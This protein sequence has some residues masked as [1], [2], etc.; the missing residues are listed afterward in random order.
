[1]KKIEIKEN[2]TAYFCSENSLCDLIERTNKTVIFACKKSEKYAMNLASQLTCKG[3]DVYT[4]ITSDGEDN[5]SIEKALLLTQF[6]SLNEIRRSDLIINIGGG[7]VCDLGA[8]VASVYMRGIKYYNVPTTLL[9]AV[10]A[11]IGGKTA[12]NTNGSKNLWGTFYQPEK[13]LIDCELIKN[14]PENIFAEGLSEIV[15]YAILNEQFYQFLVSLNDINDIR[16][17]IEQV[18]Y[19]C[20]LIKSNFVEKDEFD[21]KERKLLNLG[22]TVAHSIEVDSNY[23]IFHSVAVGVGIKIEA[24]LALEIGVISLERYN[25][26]LNLCDKFLSLPN[27]TLGDNH[28]RI[29]LN[30]KK[31]SDGMIAF[32][33][34]SEIG[35]K[36]HK[37]M[38]ETVKQILLKP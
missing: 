9:C 36:V 31:N 16:N 22:H 17:Q 19:N 20:L 12:I 13:V 28:V 6:L 26:I 32:S 34:P 27:V 8:F 11:C 10:D 3:Y 7:T 2:S 15:K 14:L 5:K 25:Q 35:A 1:M 24:K 30:D 4:Y 38:P 21:K 18:I 23:T 33:L 37:F 29:M